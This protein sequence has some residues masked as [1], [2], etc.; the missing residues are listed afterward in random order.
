MR[1]DPADFAAGPR[2]PEARAQGAPITMAADPGIGAKVAFLSRP[3]SYPE[4]TPRVETIET[5]M[6]WVFL[7]QQHAWKLKKPVRTAYLDFRSVAARRHDGEAEL[8]LNRRL[9]SGVYLDLVPLVLDTGGRFTLRDGGRIVDWLVQMRRLPAERML[10][11]LIVARAVTGEDIGRVIGRLARFYRDSVPA[12]MTPE[13]YRRRFAEGIAENEREL[14][15]PAY[16]LPGADVAAICAAQ[17]AWIARHAAQL[18][19]RVREQRVIEAHGD[20]RPE[21]I[22][23]EDEPQIIDCLE[24]SRD[25]RTLDAADE[26]AFLALE[27]ERLGVPALDRPILETYAAT[28]GDDPPA[29]LFDFYR[30][31][32]ACVRARLALHHLADPAPREPSKWAHQALT[33]LRYA[34]A[35]IVRAG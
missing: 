23:V 17:Q 31:H 11:R 2:K 10:D 22:C 25:L 34:T 14:S 15:V 33:Y 9:S 19:R 27:C 5:H 28:S 3:Q 6:S 21:H 35:H 26:L 16:G 20:L 18:D 7:T 29:A 1:V 13:C 8:V 24:F 12:P 32:R 30:S 4:A